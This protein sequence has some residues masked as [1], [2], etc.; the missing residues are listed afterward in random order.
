MAQWRSVQRELIEAVLSA[1]PKTVVVLINGGPIAL[2][3]GAAT[4][5][6][7]LEAFYGGQLG[8]DAIVETLLGTHSP[9]LLPQSAF[10]YVC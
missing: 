6:A 5:P 7:I 9:L 3:G 10:R 1:N 2:E 8:G 4:A